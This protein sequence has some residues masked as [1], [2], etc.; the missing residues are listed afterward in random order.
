PTFPDSEVSRQ[1]E[2]RR[3]QIVQQA[4]NPAAIA[5][6]AFPAIVYGRMHPYG[7][8]LNGTEAS[9]DALTRDRVAAFY[10]TYYRPHV[11]RVLVVGDVTLAEVC[12]LVAERFGAWEGAGGGGGWGGSATRRCPR[13]SSRRRR[14]TSRSGSRATSRPRRAPLPGSE[15]CSCTGCRATTSSTTPSA[16]TP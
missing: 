8:P 11:A 12:E 2:L 16:S 7:R 5:S 4:D 13:T 9:T 6:I 1:R 14:R 10:R 15:S 3:A